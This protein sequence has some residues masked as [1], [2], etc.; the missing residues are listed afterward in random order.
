MIY[1]KKKLENDA[2]FSSRTKLEIN[3][4][5]NLLDFV[6]SNNYFVYDDAIYKHTRLC[7]GEPYK[8]HRGQLMRGS[9]RRTNNPK[10]WFG[11]FGKI[12]KRYIDDSFS[13]IKSGAV[14]EFHQTL[15]SFD[16]SI[17]F[18]FE[19]EN[20]DQLAF[21]DTI[22]SRKNNTLAIG[23]Y[24]K[25]PHIDRYLDYHSHHDRKHKLSTAMTLLHRASTLPSSED[26][27]TS[28]LAYVTNALVANDYPTKFISEVIKKPR[29]KVPQSSGISRHVP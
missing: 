28:K 7:Y 1:I 21:L 29:E 2:S 12:W 26:E 16:P 9:H 22:V 25:P 17:N 27:K 3:D 15:N 8:C 14:N 4:I 13:V 5:V 6:L 24:C 10:R 18:I 23:L 11:R 20:N 19:H